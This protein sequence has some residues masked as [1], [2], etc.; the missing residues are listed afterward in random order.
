M[1]T[2]FLLVSCDKENVKAKREPKQLQMTE[3]SAA[4]IQQSNAFGIE[5]FKLISEGDEENLMFSPLSASTALTML[6]NGC[7]SDTWTQINTM[8]GYNGMT[9]GEVNQAYISLIEQLLTVDPEVQLAIANAVFYRQSFEVKTPFLDT[10]QTA[11]SSTIESLDF[12]QPTALNTIN[13]WASDNTNGK[14]PKV[15]D[16]ISSDAV[17][18]LMN[19]LYFK[20]SWTNKFDQDQTQYDE[21]HLEDG[22]TTTV[23]MMYGNIPS[24]AYGSSYFAAIELPYGQTNFSMIVMLSNTTL[25]E[26]IGNFNIQD[27]QAMTEH[28]DQNAGVIERPVLMPKFKFDFEKQLNDQLKALGMVNAFSPDLAD[29]SGISDADIYVDFVKQNT[30]IEVNEEGTE[31]AAVTTIGIVETSMPESFL[32]NRPFVFAIRERTTN[33]ILFIGKVENPEY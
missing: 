6:L 29:L 23:K 7:N 27:W 8:L 30:F 9:Q 11:F 31:A 20:G 14:I 28:F 5:L 1:A 12:S 13:G 26:M 19:A 25:A 33:T 4:V 21:F 24:A 15:L 2:L 16:E 18:F 22:A 32:I 17:M 10:M 3:K